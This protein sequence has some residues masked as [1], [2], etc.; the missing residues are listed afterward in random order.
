MDNNK[1]PDHSFI[2]WFYQYGLGCN[3]PPLYEPA[4]LTYLKSLLDVA[5]ADGILD[6]KGKKLDYWF[7]YVEFF[8][9]LNR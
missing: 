8:V 7:W 2:G 1:K 6:K 5:G 4:E 3:A 9:F